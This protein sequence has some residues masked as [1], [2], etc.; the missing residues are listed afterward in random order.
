MSNSRNTIPTWGAVVLVMLALFGG[1]FAG[2]Q[3]AF[4]EQERE[5]QHKQWIKKMNASHGRMSPNF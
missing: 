5:W 1:Y 2:R 3:S 4:N